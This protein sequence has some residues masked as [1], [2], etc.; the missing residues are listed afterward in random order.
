MIISAKHRYIFFAVPKTGT[1]SIREALH[2]YL[3]KGDWE[4]QA[5]FG[6]QLIPIPEIAAIKHGHVSVT[7]MKA[8]FENHK[9]DSYYRFAFVRNPFDRFVST[10]AFLNRE[11][12]QFKSNPLLWM[13]MALDRPIFRE[14][15]LVKPQS[16]LLTTAE[17]ELGVNFVG[18]YE[19][20]QSSLN[21]VFEHLNLPE[22]TLERRNSSNHAHYREYYDDH[23]RD[24]VAEFY[25]TDLELFSYEF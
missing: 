5:L 9:W 23:L 4:Q 8:V 7:Q 20:L 25:K 6:E 10:C 18:R 2:R 22:V 14:R 16:D 21:T 15:I 19:Y 3:V 13:K 11:N 12:P 17:G 1:H 24:L